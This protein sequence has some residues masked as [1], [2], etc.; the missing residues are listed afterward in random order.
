MRGS[1][2]NPHASARVLLI[3]MRDALLVRPH[4]EAQLLPFLSLLMRQ[5]RKAKFLLI[6]AAGAGAAAGA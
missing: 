3:L 2:G 5:Q 4:V 1:G 6:P